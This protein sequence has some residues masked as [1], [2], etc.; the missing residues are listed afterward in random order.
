VKFR[1]IEFISETK[2]AMDAHNRLQ[3]WLKT[4]NPYES[5]EDYLKANR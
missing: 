3:E 5:Y 2:V 4:N 1:I